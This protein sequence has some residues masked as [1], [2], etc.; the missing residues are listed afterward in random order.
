MP[1]HMGS[2][3]FGKSCFVG[4][5]AQRRLERIVDDMMSHAAYRIEGSLK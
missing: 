5:P 2:D 3:S 1:Q 4:R